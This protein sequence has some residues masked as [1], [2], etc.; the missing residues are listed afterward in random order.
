MVHVV[1]LIESSADVTFTSI[2]CF[3]ENRAAF[4]SDL[5]K[6]FTRASIPLDASSARATSHDLFQGKKRQTS[7]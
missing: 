4:G 2:H 7:K 5:F 3:L 6:V 1:A